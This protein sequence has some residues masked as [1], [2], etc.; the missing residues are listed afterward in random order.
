MDWVQD[1]IDIRTL[2]PFSSAENS[3][4]LEDRRVRPT[5]FLKWWQS[6]GRTVPAEL[7]HLLDEPEQ[8]QASE[9]EPA[10]LDDDA[11]PLKKT[12][13]RLLFITSAART[14]D[15][16][17]LA[18]PDGGKKRIRVACLKDS[19]LFTPSTFEYAWKVA[20]NRELVKLLNNDKYKPG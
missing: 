2:K 12:E 6:K 8:Q 5:E 3:K 13:R 18:I 19:G 4:P 1:A 14:L 20:R 17:L 7:A 16:E 11:M 15:Y 10:P 9:E